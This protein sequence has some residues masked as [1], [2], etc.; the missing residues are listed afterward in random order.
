MYNFE[1]TGMVILKGVASK[2]KCGEK[3][4]MAHRKNK[5]VQKSAV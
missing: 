5:R 1:Q 3:H 2:I 4:A